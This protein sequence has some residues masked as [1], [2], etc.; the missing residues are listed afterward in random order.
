MCETIQIVAF[1]SDGTA[2][3]PHAFI[4]FVKYKELESGKRGV[5]CR[6]RVA[7]QRH[8]IGFSVLEF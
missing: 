6:V 1:N 2:M 4:M 8:C 5:G 7:L 3:K